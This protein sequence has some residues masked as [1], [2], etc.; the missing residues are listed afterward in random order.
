[1]CTAMRTRVA[2]IGSGHIGCDLLAKINM[3]DYLSCTLFAGQREDSPGLRYARSLG[4]P[5]S[6]DGIG[7]LLRQPD[8]F[9]MMTS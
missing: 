8:R 4:A 9:D 7:A 2:I 6:A 1:M 5:T 3:S